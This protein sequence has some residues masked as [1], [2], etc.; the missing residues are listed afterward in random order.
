MLGQFAR[1]KGR[2]NTPKK[3][4][5]PTI[6]TDDRKTLILKLI[7]DGK[8][9]REV[10][11]E[12]KI[13]PAAL[14][15]WERD[16][17]DFANALTHAREAWAAINAEDGAAIAAKLPRM[18][19]SEDGERV[20]PGW[21]QHVTSRLNYLKWLIAKRDPKRYGEQPAQTTVNVENTVSIGLSEERRKDL[22]EKKQRAI[23]SNRVGLS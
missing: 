4:G 23:A 22:L 3:M 10:C 9:M 14:C 21:V 6:R 2:M 18:I 17:P 5:R 19:A 13:S 20:D 8:L 11:A 12:A 16:T 1:S 7:S 15:E